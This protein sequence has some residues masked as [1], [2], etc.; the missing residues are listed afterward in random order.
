[1]IH[2]PRAVSQFRYSQ[3]LSLSSHFQLHSVSHLVGL[4]LED[5]FQ[6]DVF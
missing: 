4:L 5:Y 6:M 1:M 3:V 2:I